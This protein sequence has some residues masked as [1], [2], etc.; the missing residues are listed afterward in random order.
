MRIY[1]TLWSHICN[2]ALIIQCTQIP[3]ARHTEVVAS[4]ALRCLAMRGRDLAQAGKVDELQSGVR[5]TADGD[6][7]GFDAVSVVILEL[8]HLSRDNFPDLCTV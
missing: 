8:L 3:S 2:G 4:D 1:A 7:D 5:W 6:S